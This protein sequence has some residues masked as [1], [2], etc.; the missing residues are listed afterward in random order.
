MERLERIKRESEVSSDDEETIFLRRF[1]YKK[2]QQ[3]FLGPTYVNVFFPLVK[4]FELVSAE[5]CL[6]TVEILTRGQTKTLLDKLAGKTGIKWIEGID[7]FTMSGNFKQ[8]QLSCTYLQ[9]AIHQSGNYY[10][11]FLKDRI[12]LG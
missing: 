2:L 1:Y 4:V 10:C 5:L 11:P 9:Q 6:E 7:T 12:F 3:C 8:V